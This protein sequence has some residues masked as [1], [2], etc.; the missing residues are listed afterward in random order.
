[1]QRVF[2]ISFLTFPNRVLCGTLHADITV[3]ARISTRSNL[4]LMFGF[5]GCGGGDEKFM[6]YQ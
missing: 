4:V 3:C 6:L 2:S 5:S 1:M